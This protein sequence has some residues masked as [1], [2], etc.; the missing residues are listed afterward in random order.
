TVSDPTPAS[1]PGPSIA[2]APDG[3]LFVGWGINDSG[4]FPLYD[5]VAYPTSRRLRPGTSTFDPERIG[6]S[7]ADDDMLWTRFRP[8]PDG[9]VYS[10]YCANDTGIFSSP[11]LDCGEGYID[12]NGT[13]GEVTDYTHAER[14]T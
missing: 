11:K 3:S 12:A 14:V 5:H 4:S 10:Y 1:A 2:V 13:L 8:G 6:G 7:G 9:R